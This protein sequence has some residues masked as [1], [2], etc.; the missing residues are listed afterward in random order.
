MHTHIYDV[1]V[2]ADPAQA[3]ADQ[4]ASAIADAVAAR[5]VARIAVSGGS[6]SPALFTRLSATG[7]DLARV[8]VWQVDE[9]VVPDGDP[10][11][12]AAQLAGL[13]WTVHEMPVTADDLAAAA[14]R[15]AR[16]LPDRFDVVHLGIGPDGHTA[17]WPP[18]DPVLGCP[19]DERVAIVAAFRGHDRMTITPPVV[20][21]AGRRLVLVTGASK[22]DVVRSWLVDGADL[23]AAAIPPEGT[24][25]HLDEEAAVGLADRLG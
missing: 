20:R 5:G 22:A 11:R 3:A 15:Y 18:G 23:P 9:R 16:G 24:T 12:N 8:D 25:I 10:D 2:G 21:R 14:A 17:S 4:L 6:T 19:D 13:P 1:R 7:A